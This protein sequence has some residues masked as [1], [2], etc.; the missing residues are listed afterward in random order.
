EQSAF[1]VSMNGEQAVISSRRKDAIGGLDIY[2]FDL[3]EIIR[4]NPVAYVKGTV[5]DAERKN[6][7]QAEVTITD[8][9][10]NRILYH[11]SSDYEDGTFLAPLP[12]GKTYALHV[13]HTGY[14]FFSDHYALD[15][16]SKI[17]DAYEVQILLSRIQPGKTEILNNVF[18]EFNQYELL[19]QSKSDLDQLVDFLMENK[20]VNIEIGGHTD[21]TGDNAYN[22]VLSE[23]RAKSVHDYLISAGIP[24][25]RLRYRGHGPSQ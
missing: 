16:P 14:L 19:P 10:T 1:S 18:F 11:E 6:P 15:A 17:E 20:E 21:N 9:S 7:L 5:I 2:F 8:V 3:P 25:E 13:R 12:F 22:Q 23:K 4:P 24:K